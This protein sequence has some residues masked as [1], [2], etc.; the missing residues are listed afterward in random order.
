MLA[1]PGTKAP[2]PYGYSSQFFIDNWSIVGPDIIAAVKGVFQSGDRASIEMMLKSFDY[3]SKPTGLVMNRNKS[4]FYCNGIDEQLIKEIELTSG[5]KRGAVPFKYLGG[6][7]H[8]TGQKESPSL[9]AWEHICQPLKQGGLG[10]KDLHLWNVATIGKYVWWVAN[11]EDHLWV[12]WVHIIYIKQSHWEDYK[13]GMGSSWTWRKIY[14]VKELL[15]QHI[16]SPGSDYSIQI[17]Y[18]RLK[19]I[20][21]VVPWIDGCVQRP[22]RL[23]LSVK[24]DSI[25][26]MKQVEMSSKDGRVLQWLDFIQTS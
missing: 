14:Q 17:G 3:F 2:G 1:I 22:E 18:Q 23:V 11:K 19:P 10:F 15:K 16:F 20:G 13:P 25:R 6:L 9:V 4:N 21:E 8:G 12:K 5:M 24:Q 7:R 26:R